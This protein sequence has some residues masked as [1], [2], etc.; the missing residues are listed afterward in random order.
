[1]KTV[2][3]DV[4]TQLDFVFPSG[5]LYVP[6]AERI[7]PSV[8]ALNRWAAERGIPLVSTAD[9]HAEDDPE[10][11][12]WPAHCVW[13]ALGQRKAEATLLSRRAVVPT[14]A[15]EV[16]ISGIQQFIVQKQ[17]LY[18][19]SNPALTPLL[20]NLGAERY[21][22]Y[23]VVTEYCVLFAALGLLKLGA[24][25]DVV[26]DAIMTLKQEDGVQAIDEIVAAGGGVTTVSAVA[27]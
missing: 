13:G 4:D 26:A 3:F 23:G 14:S 7:L 1:M 16:E 9:A 24:R 17:T 19:F 6:G 27:G 15:L 10:F 25:V 18:C 11:K 12:T 8:A 21:V 5:A 22:V 20:N 2:F